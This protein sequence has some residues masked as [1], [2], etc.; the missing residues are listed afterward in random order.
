M[1][2]IQKIYE[3]SKKFDI[4]IVAAICRQEVTLAS[5]LPTIR[6]SSDSRDCAW[7]TGNSETDHHRNAGQLAPAETVEDG[8]LQADSHQHFFQHGRS[9]SSRLPR[10]L[11]DLAV[12][13]RGGA[14]G[15]VPAHPVA[16]QRLP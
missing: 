1:R 3:A 10:T 4:M 6:E 7:I 13:A 16:H 2:A 9:V 12:L 5:E 14:P 15:E 11:V 8:C